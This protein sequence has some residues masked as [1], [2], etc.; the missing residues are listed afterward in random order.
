MGPSILGRDSPIRLVT[1]PY[2][3]QGYELS[4]ALPG[5]QEASSCTGE[6]LKHSV[7]E[8]ERCHTKEGVCPT[9]MKGQVKEQL[10]D[11]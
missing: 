6:E 11:P 3:S 5:E 2:A 7:P 9:G 8:N 4:T 10:P 1:W